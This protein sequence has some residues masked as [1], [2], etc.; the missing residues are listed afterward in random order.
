MTMS[1]DPALKP[2]EDLIYQVME[3]EY[4][5]TRVYSGSIVSTNADFT[6]DV[7]PDLEIFTVLKSVKINQPE[8]FNKYN[9]GAKC[10]FLF[11]NGDLSRPLVVAINSPSSTEILIGRTAVQKAVLGDLLKTFLSTLIAQLTQQYNLH[12]HSTS[13]GPSGPPAV[14]LTLTEPTD[15]IL[16]TKVKVS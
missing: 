3:Y 1:S 2:F 13:N 16:S 12:V 8:I 5:Y 4:A 7:K 6:V 14:P 15:S 9:S 11:E 10:S